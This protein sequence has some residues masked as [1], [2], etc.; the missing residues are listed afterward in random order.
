M[1]I[2]DASNVV[3][4]FNNQTDFASPETIARINRGMTDAGA[5]KR[6]YKLGIA[7]HIAADA[8]ARNF[9]PPCMCETCVS[10]RNLPAVMRII[11]A[12]QARGEA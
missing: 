2:N 7:R 8:R 3:S 9:P 6:A 1:N 12:H 11:A 4:L 10:V 5:M